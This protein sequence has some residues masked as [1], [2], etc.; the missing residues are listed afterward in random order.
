[1]NGN[2]NTTMKRSPSP[3]P[4]PSPS[5]DSSP[6]TTTSTT[7]IS[8]LTS[9][10]LTPLLFASFLLSF[11]LIDSRNYQHSHP[12]SLPSSSTR[13]RSP[14]SSQD[15]EQGSNGWIWRS[16]KRKVAK[17]EIAEAFELRGSI[18]TGLVI[19]GMGISIGGIWMGS[20]LWDRWQPS[21]NYPARLD[22]A[23]EQHGRSPQTRPRKRSKETQ[24]SQAPT[25]PNQ[26]ERK[27]KLQKDIIQQYEDIDIIPTPAPAPISTA[28]KLEDV[29]WKYVVSYKYVSLSF[30]LG[31]EV[32]LKKE[33]NDQGAD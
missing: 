19:G 7:T 10:F 12:P 15:K 25:R 8:S 26:R 31:L 14:R 5:T 16:K 3:S 22:E 11:F 24:A 23:P 18:M 28:V 13:G 9:L 33:R 32:S 21:A 4:S 20:W 27:N 1:M 30:F 2:L 6:N 29:I 17:M